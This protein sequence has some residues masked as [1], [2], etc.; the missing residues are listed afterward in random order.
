M[1]KR[2]GCAAVRRGAGKADIPS[3]HL[4][5]YVLRNEVADR[6]LRTVLCTCKYVPGHL[7]P[8]GYV[9][10]YPHPTNQ[11]PHVHVP[12]WRTF[13]QLKGSRNSPPP[14]ISLGMLSS[15]VVFCSSTSHPQLAAWTTPARRVAAQHSS[16]TQR[17]HRCSAGR[18]DSVFSSRLETPG[19]FSFPGRQQAVPNYPRRWKKQ[20]S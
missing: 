18:A 2:K 8:F 19:P 4:A 14:Q 3:C 15:I 1:G 9:H 20:C 12:Y 5:V 13:Q 10:S 7:S 11:F 6:G 16:G 17:G